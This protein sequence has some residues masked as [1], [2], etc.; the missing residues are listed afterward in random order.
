M[1]KLDTKISVNYTDISGEDPSKRK[2]KMEMIRTGRKNDP[3]IIL[4]DIEMRMILD[5]LVED[6]FVIGH[7]RLFPYDL[8]YQYNSDKNHFFK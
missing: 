4:N 3:A 7:K 5:S 6:G 8:L 2:I 1:S